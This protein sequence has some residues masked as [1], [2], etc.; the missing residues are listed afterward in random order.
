MGLVTALA[1]GDAST[2]RHDFDHEADLAQVAAF[3]HTMRFAYGVNAV[4]GNDVTPTV[5]Y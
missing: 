4:Q 3:D 2:V 5:Q 1:D